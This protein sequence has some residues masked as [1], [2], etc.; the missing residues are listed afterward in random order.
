MRY[1][2]PLTLIF[3]IVANALAYLRWLGGSAAF[4]YLTLV[5]LAIW[6]FTVLIA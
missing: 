2:L 3:G 1:W 4:D 6:D 5:M